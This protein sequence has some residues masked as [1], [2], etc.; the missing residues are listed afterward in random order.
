M[1]LRKLLTTLA[2][3]GAVLGAGL[4]TGNANADTVNNDGTVTVQSGDT[5]WKIANEHNTSVSNLQQANGLSGDLIY[6]GQNLKLNAAAN[7]NLTV[8]PKVTQSTTQTTSQAVSDTY[9]APK[10]T[11]ASHD[12]STNDHTVSVVNNNTTGNTVMNNTSNN[13]NNNAN[14]YS[15]NVSGSEAA[16]KAWIKNKESGGNY[17]ATNGRYYGAYQ[18]DSSYLNGDYSEANQERVAQQYVNQRYHGSW[19]EAQQHHEQYGWY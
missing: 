3:G 13:T 18:L 19:V 8:T 6:V 1:K 11:S 16:A 10:A 7:G 9:V 4:F 17:N 2:M 12:Y 15:S 14:S 5:L